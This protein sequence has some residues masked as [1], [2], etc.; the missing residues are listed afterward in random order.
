[1]SDKEWF[2]GLST[3]EARHHRWYLR[4]LGFLL[5]AAM[6]LVF[7]LFP[8]KAW[9]DTYSATNPEGKITLTKEPCNLGPWFKDWKAAKWFYQGKDYEACWRVQA[10]QDDRRQIVIIDSSGLISSVSPGAFR[11]DEG[12]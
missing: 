2:E 7:V 4:R 1:M 10:T 6:A 11:K 12:V 9:S 5:F 8:L 3:D